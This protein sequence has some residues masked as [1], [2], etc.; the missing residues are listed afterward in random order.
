MRSKPRAETQERKH[1]DRHHRRGDV[2]ATLGSAFVRAKHQVLYGSRD[3]GRT[4]PHSGAFLGSI[5]GT[6]IDAEVVILATPFDAVASALASAGDFEGRILIDATNP[7]GKQFELTVGHGT[8]GAER[9][10]SLARNARVVKGFNTAGHEVMA[11]PKLGAHPAAMFVAGDDADAT[12]TAAKLASDIGFEGI[13]LPGLARARDLEALAL[14]WVKLAMQRGLGRNIAFGLSRRTD[15]GSWADVTINLTTS[16]DAPFLGAAKKTITLLGTGNIGGSLARGW[17]RAGH[18]VRLAPRDPKAADVVD[19][20]EQGAKLVAVEGAGRGTDVLV[21]AVPA[22]AVA[23]VMKRV[24]DVSGTIVV[25]CTNGIGPGLTMLA[26]DGTSSPEQL[27]ALAPGARVVRAF[28]QQGA[29]LLRDPKFEDLRAASFV[30]SDDD[31]ARQTVLSLARDLDQ[32]AIDAGPLAMARVL[33]H[34]TLLWIATSKALGSREL[35]LT[36]LR[37]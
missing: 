17:L 9:V 24:G 25:D 37:R 5:R 18:D 4:A 20:V 12:A 16:G 32:D 13:A 27:A 3:E 10:A 21:V 22:A 14:L 23:D 8:S 35:G 31:D 33:D 2:G 30:A 6:V 19:L 36:L 15:A 7:I 11:K 26:P 1:A 28:N 29:E 34:L